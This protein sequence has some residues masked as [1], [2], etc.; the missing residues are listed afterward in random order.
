MHRLSVHK[1]AVITYGPFPTVC[2]PVLL[3]FNQVGCIAV[4]AIEQVKD[5]YSIGEYR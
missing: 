5:I 2:D 4:I 1:K 3:S